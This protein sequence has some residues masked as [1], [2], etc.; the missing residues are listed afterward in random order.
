MRLPID[1][2]NSGQL[3][4]VVLVDLL[5]PGDNLGIGLIPGNLLPLR[6]NAG[7]LFRIGPSERGVQPIGII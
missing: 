2:C 1:T 6:I 3:L 4:G 5:E 7:T